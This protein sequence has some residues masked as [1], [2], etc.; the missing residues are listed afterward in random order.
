[1]Q[2]CQI[3]ALSI[4]LMLISA[5][6]AQQ[7]CELCGRWRS[8][9]QR[10]LR[11]MERSLL[12]SEKQRQLFRNGFY[13]KL[14]VEMRHN[15][16]NAYFPGDLPEGMRWEPWQLITRS[17][18]LLTVRSFINGESNLN[19]IQLDGDCYQILQPKLGFGEWFCKE[20]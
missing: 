18:N 8:N 7:P 1:M 13:G 2:R 14:I 16:F 11:D 19:Q 9:E 20:P 15:E 10:T 12:L 17:G 5:S 4:S 3:W 6:F